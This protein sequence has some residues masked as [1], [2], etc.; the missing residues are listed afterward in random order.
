MNIS[1]K[2]AIE[3]LN[4]LQSTKNFTIT[5]APE[6]IQQ[7]LIYKFWI[8]LFSIIIFIFI[9]IIGFFIIPWFLTKKNRKEYGWDA[10]TWCPFL[11]SWVITFVI[12]IPCLFNIIPN[13]I[14]INVAP[15]IYLIEY[16]SSLI[17]R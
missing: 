10:D 17:K 3:F 12:S 16:F 14:M 7:L 13:F 11:V 6:I 2:L 15:K 5:Q 1:E 4:I 8:F 9:W